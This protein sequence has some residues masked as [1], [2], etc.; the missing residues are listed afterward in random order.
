MM[1]TI[2][3]ITLSA[4]ATGLVFYLVGILQIKISHPGDE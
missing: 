3:Y 1:E 2:G 4:L